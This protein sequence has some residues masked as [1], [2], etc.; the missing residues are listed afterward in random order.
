LAL[1]WVSVYTSTAPPEDAAD[2]RAELASDVADQL[3]STQSAEVSLRIAGRVLRGVPADVVWRLAVERAPGRAGYH[4]AHPATVLG[5]LAAALIPLTIV[6]DVLR[7]PSVGGAGD[8]REVVQAAVV[9]LSGAVVAMAFTAGL[10]RILRGRSGSPVRPTGLL[11]LVRRWTR[12]GMF[13][14]WALSA[15]WRFPAGG[16]GSV[17]AVAWAACAALFL[18]WAAATGMHGLTWL[19]R[20][21]VKTP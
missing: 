21:S 3:G 11:G 13:V 16:L 17:S 14:T 5:V 12:L 4:L 10:H 9:L 15:L 20:R 18:V 2:R 1:W 8:L 6:G 19:M 7:W